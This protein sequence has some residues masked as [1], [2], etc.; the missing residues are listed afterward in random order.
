VHSLL[1][2]ACLLLLGF[3]MQGMPW[4]DIGRPVLSSQSTKSP[5]L[6]ASPS[7]RALSG[8]DCV[9]FKL[10]RRYSIRRLRKASWLPNTFLNQKQMHRGTKLI[11]ARNP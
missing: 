1:G 2:S 8:F 10:A 5:A 3:S 11:Y 7:L 4:E 9:L 6:S